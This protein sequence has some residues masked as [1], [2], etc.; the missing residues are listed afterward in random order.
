MMTI[1]HEQFEAAVKAAVNTALGYESYPG[2]LT[3]AFAAA[4][5][6]IA[7]PEPSD[8]LVAE[9]D[10]KDAR[11]AELEGALQVAET[12]AN[13]IQQTRGNRWEIVTEDPETM[14]CDARHAITAAL[15]GSQS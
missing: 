10:A 3:A 6:T 14:A 4:G 2:V 12:L 15:E 11:I 5:I 8:A 9:R 1:T 13:A 7:P